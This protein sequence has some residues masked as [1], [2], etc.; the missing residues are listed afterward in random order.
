MSGEHGRMLRVAG[1]IPP[2]GTIS[3]IALD[4]GGYAVSFQV[5]QLPLEKAATG[6]ASP[7]GR[8]RTTL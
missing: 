6:G 8:N 5:S 1:A 7:Q 2:G 4:Y 3:A